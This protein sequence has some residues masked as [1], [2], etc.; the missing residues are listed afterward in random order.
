MLFRSV[1]EAVLTGDVGRGN[2]EQQGTKVGVWWHFEAVDPGQRVSVRVRLSDLDGE[3]EAPEPF[4]DVIAHR[5]QEADD[6][7]TGVLPAQTTADDA[8]I[9]RRAFAGLQWGK[10][11]YL[12]DVPRWLVGDP[13]QPP[14]PP[15][16]AALHR[17]RNTDWQHVNLAEVISMPDE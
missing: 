17:G 11:L 7:F 9:A 8:H 1:N 10:Q 16:R 2:P 12:Y 13:A 14:P 6:F 4:D 3:P 15:E 5:R